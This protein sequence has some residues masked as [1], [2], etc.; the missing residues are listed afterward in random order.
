MTRLGKLRSVTIVALLLVGTV[1]AVSI[2]SLFLG[3]LSPVFPSISPV[4]AAGGTP[5][6]GFDCGL[7]ASEAVDLDGDGIPDP[8]G[9]L[10]TVCTAVYDVD[11]SAD[12]VLEPLVSD[13]PALFLGGT[14][15]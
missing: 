11:A 4:N 13:N 3:T 10:D 5:V 7:G 1:S 6:L 8:D 9:A 15:G 2:A 12:L 14:G